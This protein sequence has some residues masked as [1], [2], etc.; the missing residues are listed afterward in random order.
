M[1]HRLLGAL[2]RLGPSSA[3]EL[4]LH[5]GCPPASL[6]Y[7]LHRLRQAGVLQSETRARSGQRSET[8]FAL[9]GRELVIRAGKS[10][11]ASAEL[12]RSGRGLLR[13]AARLYAAAAERLPAKRGRPRRR[14]LL[15]QTQARLSPADLAELERRL[16]EAAAFMAERDDPSRDGFHCLTVALSPTALDD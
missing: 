12:A 4:G 13:L 1:A 7:H 2:E 10:R 16:E 6:Y 3:R 9:R 15:I 8:V 14:N 11:R 5:L